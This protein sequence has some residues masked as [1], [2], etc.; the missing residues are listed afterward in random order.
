MNFLMYTTIISQIAI[1]VNP[2]NAKITD[3]NHQK[4]P[5]R[6]LIGVIYVTILTILIVS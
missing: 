5:R 3:T 2:S 4:A 1:F 6:E